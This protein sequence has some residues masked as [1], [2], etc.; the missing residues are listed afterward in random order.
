MSI[1]KQDDLANR[2]WEYL[3]FAIWPFL[4]FLVALR[5]FG[6]Q[7]S[8]GIIILFYA[9]FGF[10]YLYTESSDSSRHA[11]SFVLTGKYPFTDF[12]NIVSGM[13]SVE[14]QK[15]DFF[16]NLIGFMVSRFTENP[17]YFFLILSL[18]LGWMLIK[19]INMLHDLYK[20]HSNS[21]SLIFLFFIFTLIPPSRILS[22]RHYLALLVFIYGFYNYQKEKKFIFLFVLTSS[23]FFHFGFLMAVGLFYIY[24]LLG[25]RNFI[26]YALILLSVIYAEQAS[27]FLRE[28]GTGLYVGGL[29]QIVS[30]YTNE[31]YLI[32]V[33]EYQEGRN[34]ILNNYIRWTTLFML[35]S[36]VY[37]KIKI[38]KFNLIS[39]NIYSF[40]LLFFAFVN[41]TQGIESI[42]NR[43]GVV[44]QVLGCV[45]YVH[46][47]A[48]NTIKVN[49]FFKYISIAFL[50]LN[51]IILV[52]ITI[53]YANMLIITPFLP[54]S[55]LM[56]SDFTILSL[57]K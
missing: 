39:E 51:L 30:G 50:S 42:T 3:L 19:N 37:H 22:F 23:I 1:L 7:Y 16:M 49:S 12:I 46:L 14:G 53:E 21:I 45:F 44:F 17:Q 27:T 41:F 31:K 36:I 35:I 48:L 52:R 9:L 28:I 56:N 57:I 43:F 2:Y 5:S 13:Y 10:T 4:A 38:K 55:F 29:D 18:L 34:Y 24:N 25:N 8:K 32:R 33:S 6:W 15:P 40:I 26:Y 11:E 54:L 47:Y 20:D